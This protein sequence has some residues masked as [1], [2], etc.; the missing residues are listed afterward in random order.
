MLKV[1]YVQTSVSEV[2][3]GLSARRA[4]KELSSTIIHMV[5][6]NHVK[7]N[8]RTPFTVARVPLAKT[9][10]SS[11]VKALIQLLSI[12]NVLTLLSSNS[13]ELVALGPLSSY[14]PFS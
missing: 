2:I 9:A 14:L 3:V 6:A 10:I 11:A 12:R 13:P 4:L 8:P 1:R 7:T 5:F